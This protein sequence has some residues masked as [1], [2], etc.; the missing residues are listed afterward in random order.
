MEK[1]N[2][3]KQSDEDIL[4]FSNFEI[5]EEKINIHDPD[6]DYNILDNDNESA[7]EGAKLLA[8]EKESNYDNDIKWED[9]DYES[10]E[11]A[12]VTTG[13]TEGSKYLLDNCEK[14]KILMPCVLLYIVN[15]Q[16]QW[17]SNY[18]QKTQ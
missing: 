18:K 4:L 6:S 9:L 2:N 12:S 16:V 15:D 8:N 11:I 7:L 13:S 10:S 14:T 3:D 17:C 1:I 5:N